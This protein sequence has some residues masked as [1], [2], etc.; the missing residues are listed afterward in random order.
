MNNR[1]SLSVIDFQEKYGDKGAID[2]AAKLGLSIIDFDLSPHHVDKDGDVYTLGKDGVK[3][4]FASIAAYAT[5]RGVKI[6]QTHGRFNGYGNTPEG[7]EIF[8]KNAE[9]DCIA[10]AALGSKYTVFHT[11]AHNHVGDLPD[12]RMFEIGV[13]LF[14][15]ALPFAKEHGIKIAAETH[16]TASKYNKMEFFGIPEN[17]LELIK[18]VRETSPAGDALCVCVDTGHTNLATNMGYPS[19]GDVIRL[20]GSLVEVLHLHDNNG[21]KDQHKILGTGIIDWKDVFAALDEIGYA[22]YYNLETMLKH[23]GDGFEEAEA[24]FSAK[25]LKHMLKIKN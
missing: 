2:A 8:K 19:V 5:E 21:I 11:P 4:Y 20:L 17:L 14:S 9:L 24:E 16:G 1:I 23:F 25:V 12:E 7:D 22:G 18:R 3:E 15:I 13:S 6:G 10:T